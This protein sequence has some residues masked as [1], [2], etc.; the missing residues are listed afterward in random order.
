MNGKKMKKLQK[1]NRQLKKAKGQRK[2]LLHEEY[3]NLVNEVKRC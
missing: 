2:V 3:I 1:I